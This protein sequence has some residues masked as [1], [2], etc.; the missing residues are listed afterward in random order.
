[1]RIGEKPGRLRVNGAAEIVLDDQ[2]LDDF[3]G[4][5]MLV[6]LTPTDIFP[7]CPRYIPRHDLIEPSIYAPKADLAP[8][9]P[10]WKSFDQFKD[11]V[12]P[13]RR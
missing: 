2:A 9:E 7:N 5:Q 3:P 4:A 6:R 13:R 10:A 1:M 8:V 12:P 11:I